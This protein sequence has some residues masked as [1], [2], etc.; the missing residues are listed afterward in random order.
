[1]K[2]SERIPKAIAVSLVM[3]MGL[4]MNM[5]D[6]SIITEPF[7][8]MTEEYSQVQVDNDSTH[9]NAG[10]LYIYTTSIIKSGIQHLISNI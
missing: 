9:T 8:Q 2:P 5:E 1:M 7:R 3:G 6:K 4:L 10:K